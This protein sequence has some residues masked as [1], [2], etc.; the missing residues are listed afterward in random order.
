M[1]AVNQS[2]EESLAFFSNLLGFS[3]TDKKKDKNK[4]TTTETDEEAVSSTTEPARK[5]TKGKIRN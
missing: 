2:A 4:G 5:R 1:E 3:S